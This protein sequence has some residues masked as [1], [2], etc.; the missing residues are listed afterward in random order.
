[1]IRLKLIK[2]CFW[3][4]YSLSSASQFTNMGKFTL[5]RM[6]PVQ[7]SASMKA[8]TYQG[9][10]EFI[11]ASWNSSGPQVSRNMRACLQNWIDFHRL[12][13]TAE[14]GSEFSAEF[15]LQFSKF[16]D[17]L[18]E[19]VKSTTVGSKK[20]LI[21]KA[22]VQYREL[23]NT[24]GLPPG[25]QDALNFLI[26]RDGITTYELIKRTGL[27]RQKV[28]NWVNGISV[29]NR[30]SIPAIRKVEQC[31]ELPEGTLSRAFIEHRKERAKHKAK[32][33]TT[34]GKK[35]AALVRKQYRYTQLPAHIHQEWKSFVEYK[36]SPYNKSGLERKTHWRDKGEKGS[37]SVYY[38]M[39]RSFF[40][41]LVLPSTS[42]PQISGKSIPE[43]NLSYAMLTDAD[44]ILDYIEFRRLRSGGYTSETLNFLNF[45]KSC[46]Q[47]RWGYFWQQPE[48][49]IELILRD[50]DRYFQSV[51]A[52]VR[53]FVC[54]NERMNDQQK[55]MLIDGTDYTKTTRFEFIWKCWCDRSKEINRNVANELECN[56]YI[57]QVR[58][59][60]GPIADILALS[61]P[62]EALL[63]MAANMEREL[64]P[65]GN[66]VKRAIGFRNLL[67]V[68]L[69]ISNPLRRSH[70]SIMTWNALNT[71]NLYQ[72]ARGEWR[73]RFAASDF[74]NERGAANKDYDVPIRAKFW[75]Y[76][77][78]YI[79]NCRKY[80]LGHDKCD[81]VFRPRACVTNFIRE[82]DPMETN[83]LTEMMRK[84][85][86]WNYA[87]SNCGFGMHSFRHIIATDYLRHNPNGFQ[88]VADILHDKLATVLK[89]YAHL[90]VADGMNVFYSYLEKE[91]PGA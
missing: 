1:M 72:N 37:P 24:L 91:F 16:T 44:L 90:D 68:K 8:V 42:D 48:L 26:S 38:E 11:A 69:L 46:L 7:V 74:K 89:V 78:E 56:N 62:I 54:K 77:E 39:L 83:T 21:R 75:P 30:Q 10:V 45:C 71:G 34:Y 14:I 33:P 41:Y 35:Q 22:R 49:G 18:V 76:I 28:Y 65:P 29:P 57:Q 23:L 59:V 82:Q 6:H 52:K 67:L 36:T 84:Q 27:P 51:L 47:K 20:S 61:H 5:S 66:P 86:T 50:D 17:Y 3:I 60:T 4:S 85:I 9:L 2:L 12:D 15:D 63:E 70:F 40:G 32:H 81:Y 43:G 73:M 25:F 55:E 13:W 19:T 58:K 64:P 79:F 53:K 80:L 87:P 31:F 88:V